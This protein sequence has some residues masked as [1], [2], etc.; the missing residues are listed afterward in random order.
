MNLND[1]NN[2]VLMILVKRKGCPYCT[3]FDPIYENALKKY[4]Q[5]NHEEYDHA[6]PEQKNAFERDYSSLLMMLE[7]FPTV[8]LRFKLPTGKMKYCFADTVQIDDSLPENKQLDEATDRFINN[9]INKYKSYMSDGSKTYTSVQQ[10]GG[11]DFYKKKYF[12]Y[13]LKY[14][15]SLKQ[16]IN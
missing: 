5:I 14:I 12:K 8:F 16:T 4:P 15:N 10:H 13:K 1:L 3:D 7:G 9:I 2:E 6:F 11:E